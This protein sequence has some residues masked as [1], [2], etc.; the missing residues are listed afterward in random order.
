MTE[1]KRKADEII[2]ISKTKEEAQQ[3]S[4]I[5]RKTLKEVLAPAHGRTSIEDYLFHSSFMDSV[6]AQIHLHFMKGATG[7][8][9]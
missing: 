6:D 1:A 3:I 5:I 8:K 9:S 2:S 7:I 4:A